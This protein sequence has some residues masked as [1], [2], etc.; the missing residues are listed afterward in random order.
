MPFFEIKVADADSL[1][2]QS[3]ARL[4]AT[5]E[6]CAAQA[7]S[8]FPSVLTTRQKGAFLRSVELRRLRN[9]LGTCRRQSGR[10]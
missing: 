5:P 7:L 4:R 8:T 3:R 1:D 10:S 6:Y 9:V 2:V